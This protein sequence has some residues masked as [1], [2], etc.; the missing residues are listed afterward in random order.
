MWE[1][2][3]SKIGKGVFAALDVKSGTFTYSPEYSDYFLPEAFLDLQTE[4]TIKR[5]VS[6]GVPGAEYVSKKINN[7]AGNEV[8]VIQGYVY[9]DPS[10]EIIIILSR[11]LDVSSN[12]DDQYDTLTGLYNRR[13]F[14]RTLDTKLSYGYEPDKRAYVIFFDI[15][16]FKLVND[17]FGMSQGDGLLNYIANIIREMAGE[18]GFGAR[19]SSD[20]F[21]YVVCL[22]NGKI[23]EHMDELMKRI[24]E[25]SLPFEI[26]CNAGVY[27]ITDISVPADAIIDRAI[28]AQ[29][30]IKGSYTNKYIFYS[31]EIRNNLIGELEISGMMA[32]ALAK[33]QFEIYYQPQYNHS[34]GRLVGA[35]ALVR[36]IHPEKGLISPGQFIPVFEKNGFITKLDL[37]VFEKVC[38]FIK[39]CIDNGNVVVPIS[40]NL[41]R[42]DIFY[43]D[44]IEI[45]ERIRSKY[46]IPSKYVRVEIT[47]SAALGNS[48]FIN[49]AVRKLHDYGFIVEMDDFGSGYSSLNI[50]KDIEFDVIKLDM[51]FLQSDNEATGRGGTIL[52]SVVRMVNWLK[53][54]VIAEGVETSS[55]ADFLG[56][57]GCEYIQGFLYS[58]PLP[59]DDYL[60]LLSNSVIGNVVS[61]MDLV[62][63]LDVD[64]F[65]SDDSLETLIFSHFVGGAAVIDYRD[66]QAELLRVN[67]KF[68]KE[69]GM[70]MSEKEMVNRQF[71][72]IFDEENKEI[73]LAAAKQAIATKEEQEFEVWCQIKSDCCGIDNICLRVSLKLIG[74]SK[75][76]ELLYVMI[77][78]ITVEKK[79]YQE[80]L[81]SE[82]RF[83]AA[84]EQAQIYY[85]E[86]DIAKHEMKPCFRC[87]RDLGLP[88]V[89]K[90]YPDSAIERGIFPQDY[91]D[92]Y[93]DWHVQMANGAKSFEAVIPL[94]KDRIPFNV[95]YTTEFDEN[96]FAVKAYGSA[97]LVVD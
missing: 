10:K 45:L 17:M 24:S 3:Q 89:L 41:T 59:E 55:Q 71:L 33:E 1:A 63:G 68:L 29:K 23:I 56:S 21:I 77:R 18:F 96:G 48:K 19:L 75:D 66:G 8:S 46:D 61:P 37:Y 32:E 62:A 67:K 86:Y 54:P 70:N 58:R 7:K 26:T 97:T 47:E 16:R 53:L 34:S 72:H 80:I 78:N 6:E 43:P 88:S 40:I 50:L 52:S 73:A 39:K 87:M 90:N 94:T 4:S 42:Y 95:R 74:S 35:E 85:W 14:A 64:K 15:L 92:M 27:E 51:R 12:I 36:W 44:F 30:G 91:A 49:E 65:W 28:M 81:D 84:S 11:D 76:A 83:K 13:T 57:I 60:S 5:I 82:K 93:R 69:V 79:Y 38:A 20:R 22:E 9:T 31:E 2:K 25:Y